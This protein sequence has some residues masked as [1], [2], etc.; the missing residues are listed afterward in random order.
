MLPLLGI[1]TLGA[2]LFFMVIATVGVFRLPGLRHRVH[3]VGVADSVG[4]ALVL[5]GLT[6][7]CGFSVFTVKMFVLIVLLWITSTTACNAI[8]SSVMPWCESDDKDGG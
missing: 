3:A 7:Q 8:A 1:M 4:V 6:M 5:C 2:G